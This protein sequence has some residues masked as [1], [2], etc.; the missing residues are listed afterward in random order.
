MTHSSN[1]R[2]EFQGL[3]LKDEP[4]AISFR[5]VFNRCAYDLKTTYNEK[6]KHFYPGVVLELF[7][8]K[9]LENYDINLVDSCTSSDNKVVNRLWPSQRKVYGCIFFSQHP[10]ARLI[11]LAYR[12]KKTRLITKL[13]K[14]G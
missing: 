13:A 12:F 1:R 4:L 11:K 6:Y 10:L 7:N 3:F 8:L 2:V 9:D 5:L 14:R